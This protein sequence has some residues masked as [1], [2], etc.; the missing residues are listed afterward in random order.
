MDNSIDS[1]PPLYIAIDLGSTKW[2]LGFHDGQR[3]K[4]RV[5]T[6]PAH[7]LSELRAE[8]EAARRQFGYP[9]EYRVVSCFEAGRDG[10]WL[11][12]EM[13]SW[14]WDNV[15]VDPGSIERAPK[16]RAKTD[17][18][19]TATLMERLLRHDR[20]DRSVWS[21]VAVPPPE[22]EDVRRVERER[23]RLKKERSALRSAFFSCLALHGVPKDK[24]WLKGDIEAIRAA[25]GRSLPRHALAE[26]RRQRERLALVDAQLSQLEV[27]R[28]EAIQEE[29]RIQRTYEALRA[30]RGIGELSAFALTVESFGWRD[31]DNTRQVGASIGLAP[32]PHRS[33]QTGYERGISKCSRP[34]LRSLMVQLSWL[35]LKYQPES[36]LSQ[37]Y[38]RRFGDAGGRAKRVGIVA[39]ARKLYVQLW[40]LTTTGELPDDILVAA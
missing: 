25:T 19:D 24:T 33:D 38:R 32:T 28:D 13:L 36:A 30:V 15:V 1:R 39:L 21:V 7:G 23:G 12:R 35:W 10:F 27:E 9:A 2:T 8:A 34:Q 22:V 31:F 26:L 40:K 3:R 20:G 29:P 16:K 6:V 5:K 18:L 37:W 14:G 4:P 11:H 17:R